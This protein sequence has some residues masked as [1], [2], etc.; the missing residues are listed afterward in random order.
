MPDSDPAD[1]VMLSTIYVLA[2]KLWSGENRTASRSD[3]F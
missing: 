2:R 1:P 3:A